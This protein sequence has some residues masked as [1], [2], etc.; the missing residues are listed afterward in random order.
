MLGVSWMGHVSFCDTL[1]MAPICLSTVI[2]LVML[3]YSVSVHAE[4]HT[5][6]IYSILQARARLN[7]NE[8]LKCDIETNKVIDF[9][10]LIILFRPHCVL[11]WL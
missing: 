8:I 7:T 1:L 4:C 5:V 11:A 10:L 6:F 9:A 2:L 3:L